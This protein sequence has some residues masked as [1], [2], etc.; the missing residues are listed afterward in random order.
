MNVSRPSEMMTAAG[1]SSSPSILG[2]P[3]AGSLG[4]ALGLTHLRHAGGLR[5]GRPLFGIP[6]DEYATARPA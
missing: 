3:A 5:T 1:A 4:R 2:R 6:R